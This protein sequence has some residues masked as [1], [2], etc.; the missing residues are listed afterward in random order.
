MIK[1][2][3]P[4]ELRDRTSVQIKDCYRTMLKRGEL[5]ESDSESI[6]EGL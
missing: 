4:M 1:S 5:S 6:T 2:N 3:W